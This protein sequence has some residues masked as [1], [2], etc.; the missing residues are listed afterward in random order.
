ME[1]SSGVQHSNISKAGLDKASESSAIF[2][3]NLDK[4]IL[5]NKLKFSEKLKLKLD[6]N[7]LG[8]ESSNLQLR[9]A[10]SSTFR[11]TYFYAML[12]YL[13]YTVAMVVNNHLVSTDKRNRVYVIFAMVHVIDAFMFLYSWDDKTYID[14]ETWP[15]YLN[16]IGSIL[17]LWSST[18]YDTL[19]DTSPNGSETP[20]PNFYICR[21]TELIASTLEVFAT[22]GWIYI[23]YKNLLER[24][25]DSLFITPG[26]GLTIYDPDLHACWTLLVASLLYLWYNIDI[27][28]N[29]RRYDTSEVYVI[30]DIFYLINSIFYML[31][32]LR[33]LGWF[34]YF[35]S[36]CTSLDEEVQE[37]EESTCLLRYQAIVQ[38]VR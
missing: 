13:S 33:D 28:R 20:S 32:T 37:N 25:G 5:D 17:Y 19:F 29:S 9:K 11:S 16:I 35:P 15:E 36:L 4:N 1:E 10:C 3:L 34:W 2:D 21:Q 24:F 8:N 30:A 31:S 12:V 22:L 23:T 14:V 7:V 27:S 38:H 18:I 26:R 6:E